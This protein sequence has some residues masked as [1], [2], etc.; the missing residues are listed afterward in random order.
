MH[1][2]TTH[3]QEKEESKQAGDSESMQDP[4]KINN[5]KL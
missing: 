1:L 4:L 5:Y 3:Q 2:H